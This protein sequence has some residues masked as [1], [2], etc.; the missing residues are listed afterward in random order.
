MIYKDA[1]QNFRLPQ[2]E[3]ELFL[4]NRSGNNTRVVQQRAVESQAKVLSIPRLKL[5]SGQFFSLSWKKSSLNGYSTE[6]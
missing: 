5:K 4:K 3:N 6:A 1:Q 2:K